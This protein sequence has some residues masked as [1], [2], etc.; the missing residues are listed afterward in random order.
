M[1][2]GGG[3][4]VT[5]Y[6]SETVPWTCIEFGPPSAMIEMLELPDL[7]LALSI[8]PSLS[9]NMRTVIESLVCRVSIMIA[10][11]VLFRNRRSGVR[12]FTVASMPSG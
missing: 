10:A 7:W 5:A 3:G 8:R 6:L 1:Y 12:Q 11:E 4:L 2:S 9:P